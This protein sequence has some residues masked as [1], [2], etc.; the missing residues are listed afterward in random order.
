MV[1]VAA[2]VVL[3]GRSPRSS[4][5]R[6]MWLPVSSRNTS[7]SVGVRSVRSRTA[8]SQVLRATA[9][10]LMAAEPLLAEMTS[11]LPWA[12]TL[13]TPSRASTIG[14]SGPASPSTR[15]TI[16]SVPTLCFS[17]SGVPSATIRP[18]SM[19]PTRSQ[20]R[21]ASS[22]YCVVRKIVMPSS[23]LSRRTSSHT[24]V[25][26]TGSRPVVGSSRNR[27][28]GLCTSAAARSSRRFMPPE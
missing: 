5:S 16:T 10:G 12:S 28:S 4:S 17:S 13:T 7:S 27:I 25:R 11:S 14:R 2:S 20:R 1:D 21:S 15:A 18:R 23:A 24:L 26:L 6:S 8:T 19:M 9:T 22:R 3:I